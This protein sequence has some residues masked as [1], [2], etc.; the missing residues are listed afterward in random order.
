MKQASAAW[1][2]DVASPQPHAA[3]RVAGS[4]VIAQYSLHS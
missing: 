4:E 1:M 2:D 3:V